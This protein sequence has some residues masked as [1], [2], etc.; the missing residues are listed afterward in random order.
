MTSVENFILLPPYPASQTPQFYPP[1]TPIFQ[2]SPKDTNFCPPLR[3][4]TR[5]HLCALKTA[6]LIFWALLT[7]VVTLTNVICLCQQS[8]TYFYSRLLI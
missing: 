3:P 6:K 8:M 1:G 7:L 4:P 5:A 2:P